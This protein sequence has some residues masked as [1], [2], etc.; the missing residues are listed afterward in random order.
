LNSLFK[1]GYTP[2]AEHKHKYVFLLAYAAS[3]HE[4]WGEVNII[5]IFKE[6]NTFMSN[7]CFFIRDPNKWKRRRG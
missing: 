7:E 5:S 3:V 1:P 4:T 2:H 6:K